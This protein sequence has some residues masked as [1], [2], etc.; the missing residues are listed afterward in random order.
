MG[1][2]VFICGV[3]GAGKSVAG[4][5][6]ADLG[7]FAVE[8]LPV[9]LLSNFLSFLKRS[10]HRLQ[11]SAISPDIDSALKQEQFVSI[12]NALHSEGHSLQILFLDCKS[13]VVV[14]R[15]GQTRRPH[16]GFDPEVD[17]SLEDAIHR[18]KQRLFG[19]REL[20]SVLIDT[21]EMNVHDLR[22]EVHDWAEQIAPHGMRIMRVN[23]LSFG[24]RHG[25]PID[26]DLLID[27]RF[28]P[29]PY[30][31]ENLRPQSGLEKDV[32]D[33]VLNA[34][35]AS[36]FFQRYLNLL[37]FLLREY[38]KNGRSY[39]NIGV[40]CTGGRHR[41][42]AVAASLAEQVRGI[43]MPPEFLVGVKHRDINKPQ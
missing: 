43:F 23:F 22:R 12:V 34:E 17:T 2:L 14:K 13:E 6:M 33:Y 38:R 30:F 9:A 5:A 31:I 39:L 1:P 3:S 10:S 20:A 36:E 15:Y 32:S 41:S 28:L 42:V 24:F 27:V 29:N 25:M 8:N 11:K 40:G 37:Q 35:A 4:D 16:P 26:C 21:S 19:L 18:E 7:F